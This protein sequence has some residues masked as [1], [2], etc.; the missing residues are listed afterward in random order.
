MVAP[1]RFCSGSVHVAWIGLE[2]AGHEHS[3]VAAQLLDQVPRKGIESTKYRA[4]SLLVVGGSPGLTG[5]PMLA[6]L[7][8]FR[9]DAGYVTVAAPESCL[10]AI[11]SWL[12]E[13]V[14]R[15]LPEDA[16]GRVLPRSVEGVLEAAERADAVVVGPGLGRSAG[17]RD[18]VRMLLEQLPVPVVLDA[19]GLWELD[20]FQRAAPTVMTPHTGE[21]ARLLG[22]EAAEI[23]ERRL[24]FGAARCLDLRLGRAAERSRHARD[25]ATRRRP[26]LGLRR[27][28]ARDRGNRRRPL[29][30]D[31]GVSRQGEWSRASPLPRVLPRT[32]SPPGSPR[33]RP[34]LSRA[35]C[36]PRSNVL[37][38]EEQGT[39]PL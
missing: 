15:P 38:G 16:A 27:A 8:A 34:G 37:D 2:P 25:G 11:E 17:T 32:A 28:L 12:L 7:A 33:P 13:A 26:R 21:L 31:R 22:T 10:P 1:G 6:A 4:G 9:A 39:D 14:K 18:F 29:G 19:D 35:T 3:L 24:E 30:R 36:C 20:P 23:D 5:A